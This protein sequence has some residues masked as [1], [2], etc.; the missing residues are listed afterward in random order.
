MN[1]Q[2]MVTDGTVSSSHYSICVY[3]L[4][5]LLQLLAWLLG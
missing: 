1:S 2:K 5:P 3:A 4:M